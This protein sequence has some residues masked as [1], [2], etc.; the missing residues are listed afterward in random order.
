MNKKFL[1]I[2]PGENGAAT[3]LLYGDIMEGSVDCARVVAELSELEK[4][5]NRIEVRINS[6]GG[7]VYNGMAIYNALRNSKANITIFVDGVAASMAAI[8][9][10]CGKP[11]YMS[12]YA[13]LM[14]HSVSVFAHGKIS[15]IRTLADEMEN[16]QNSLANMIADRCGMKPED[17][18]AKYFD[19][20]DHWITAQEAVQMKL[21]DDIY[22]MKSSVKP[23]PEDDIY[24]FFNL[25]KVYDFVPNNKNE[26][27]LIDEIK[28]IP[29]FANVAENGI[30]D[31]IK[32][33]ENKATKADAL[34]QANATLQARIAELEN[35]EV[36]TFLNQAV[37]DGK[38]KEDQKEQFAKL[39]NS[40]RET[41]EALINS[42]KATPA[43]APR[44]T[45][46]I[47]E[48]GNKVSFENKSWDDLDKENLLATLKAQ[49]ITL[50]SA[51]FKEKFGVDYQG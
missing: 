16:L 48:N 40:D 10:L 49:N 2:I 43:Q 31:T 5:Y 3:I 19:E 4:I 50:F 37:K 28:S 24:N 15:E 35:K 20:K 25:N 39:M 33:L 13:K 30:V 17:I 29:S 12:P 38:I 41:T 32:G 1:N 23:Q 6:K 47:D 27:A 36:E 18:S 26:M 46:F 22:E 45:D 51:K 7:D 44:I 8:I 42:M 21:A 34:A 14:L 11:L 9:A